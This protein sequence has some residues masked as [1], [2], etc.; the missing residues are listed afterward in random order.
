[1][2]IK[3]TKNLSFLEPV[4]PTNWSERGKCLSIYIVNKK[5]KQKDKRRFCITEGAKTAKFK[6][7]ENLVYPFI[8]VPYRAEHH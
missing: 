1:M 2:M 7:Q 8:R 6:G 5:D 4:I 3:M